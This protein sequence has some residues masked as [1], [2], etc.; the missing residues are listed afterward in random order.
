MNYNQ[1]CDKDGVPCLVQRFDY[2]PNRMSLTKPRSFHVELFTGMTVEI[3]VSDL[4]HLD[5]FIPNDGKNELS[6]QAMIWADYF[7]EDMALKNWKHWNKISSHWNG[8]VES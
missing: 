8:R 4:G 6:P 7:I 3:P 1:K 5:E 2:R